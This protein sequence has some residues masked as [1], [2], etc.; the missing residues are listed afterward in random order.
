MR[1][2]L[3]WYVNWEKVAREAEAVPPSC[4]VYIRRRPP[5][6]N[7][8]D[9]FVRHRICRIVKLNRRRG[10]VVSSARRQGSNIAEVRTAPSASTRVCVQGATKNLTDYG[11]SIWAAS[12]ACCTSATCPT[13]G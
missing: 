4:P 2:T 5:V 1:I 6:Y 10:N 9:Q 12:T 7:L 8:F 11:A 3:L 13:G